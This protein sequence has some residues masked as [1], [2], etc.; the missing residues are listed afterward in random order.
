MWISL[1]ARR[2]WKNSINSQKGGLVEKVPRKNPILT[3]SAVPCIN[4]E[5]CVDDVSNQFAVRNSADFT[6]C[7]KRNLE[8]VPEVREKKLEKWS[9][10]HQLTILLT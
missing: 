4:L 1:Q 2:H 3:E 8:M 6:T 5:N 9:I 10:L 7:L